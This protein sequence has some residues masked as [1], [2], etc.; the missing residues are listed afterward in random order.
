MAQ[1]EHFLHKVHLC[2]GDGLGVAQGVALLGCTRFSSFAHTLFT[3]SLWV[4]QLI[5]A[6]IFEVPVE[7]LKADYLFSSLL[8]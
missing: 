8:L 2:L 7:F 6:V 1:L 5:T 4:E 3:M